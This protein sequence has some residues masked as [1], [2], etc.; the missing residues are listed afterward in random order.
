MTLGHEIHE[1]SKKFWTEQYTSA[2]SQRIQSIRTLIPKFQHIR[3]RQRRNFRISPQEAYLQ[4]CS[5]FYLLRQQEEMDVRMA[6]IQA[7]AFG[8]K[9][10]LTVN[11]KEIVREDRALQKWEGEA[12]RLKRLT[13]DAKAKKK[14]MEVNEKAEEENDNGRGDAMVR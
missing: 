2:I 8:R 13:V 11:E 5:E 6:I 9:M 4:A 1:I 7:R 12:Q 14:N 3:R 10:G